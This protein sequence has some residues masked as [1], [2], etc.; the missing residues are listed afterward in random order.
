MDAV[1]E[2]LIIQEQSSL[3]MR[4]LSMGVMHVPYATSSYT[5]CL[6][7]C[8]AASLRVSLCCSAGESLTPLALPN[9]RIYLPAYTP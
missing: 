1:A 2:L 5:T 8:E 3:H 6:L 4:G 9:V 7:L